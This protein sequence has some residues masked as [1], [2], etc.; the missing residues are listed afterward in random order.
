MTVC[1]S[2]HFDQFLDFTIFGG[3]RSVDFLG[4]VF[5][6]IVIISHTI[7]LELAVIQDDISVPRN[8]F[9]V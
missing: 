5:S 3:D 8:G 7:I 1:L 6:Q 2:D 9:H 4:F